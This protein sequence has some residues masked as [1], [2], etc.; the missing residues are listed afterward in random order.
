MEGDCS[1]TSERS[2]TK[3]EFADLLLPWS[4]EEIFY[5]DP[6]KLQV[7]ECV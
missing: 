3:D 4:V 5:E 1:G 7:C 6:Y 2:W